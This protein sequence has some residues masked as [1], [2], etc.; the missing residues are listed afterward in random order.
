[1]LD[2]ILWTSKQFSPVFLVLSASNPHIIL[3]GNAT[4]SGKLLFSVMYPA[5]SDSSVYY[6][7]VLVQ[8]GGFSIKKWNSFKT[9]IKFQK[10]Y[11]KETWVALT[12]VSHKLTGSNFVPDISYHTGC[13]C[14]FLCLQ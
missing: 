14:D 12:L 5:A 10:H 8:E 2:F 11:D 4:A 9:T 3:C 6:S 1:L 13:F 7:G